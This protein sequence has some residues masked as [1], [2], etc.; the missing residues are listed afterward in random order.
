[1]EG[2]ADE[3]RKR[4]YDL[5]AKMRDVDLGELKAKAR[6]DLMQSLTPYKVARE[7]ARQRVDEDDVRMVGAIDERLAGIATKIDERQRNRVLHLSAITEERHRRNVSHECRF[8][9]FKERFAAAEDKRLTEAQ[10]KEQKKQKQLK[11]AHKES[12][13]YFNE[14]LQEHEKRRGNAGDRNEELEQS[15]RQRAEDVKNK[16]KRSQKA[17][18]A[19]MQ[20]RAHK[21]MLAQEQRRLMDDD[22]RKM[23]QRAKRLATRKKMEILEKEYSAKAMIQ[24]VRSREQRM[25][26]YRYR[27][28]VT[29]NK[30]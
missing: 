30:M 23:N 20:D 26:D 10:L 27:N 6:S 19:F 2:A 1:V 11:R 16:F 5:Q 4:R 25:V 22:M 21:N 17:V 18:E 7:S 3:Q 14:F 13:D 28:R 15:R 12:M 29:A 24:E 9:D 8:A